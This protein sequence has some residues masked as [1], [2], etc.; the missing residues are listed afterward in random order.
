MTEQAVLRLEKK[1]GGELSEDHFS[2]AMAHSHWHTSSNE[3][4]TPRIDRFSKT[5]NINW[6]GASAHEH[7]RD[8]Y[9]QAT[10]PVG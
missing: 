3:A 4:L 10:A 1:R 8:I 6:G 2:Q 9:I 5:G 7:T